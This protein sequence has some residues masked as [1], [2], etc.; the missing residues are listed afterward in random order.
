MRGAVCLALVL[1]M[2]L[3]NKD[4][5]QILL[6]TALFILLFTIVF[7][8]GSTLPLIKILS[9]LFPNERGNRPNKRKRSRKQRNQ[10]GKVRRSSPVLLSKTQ[11]MV[12]FDNSEHFTTTEYEDD[13]NNR[14]TMYQRK[15]VFTKINERIVRPLFVRKFT[16]QERQENKQRFKNLASEVLKSTDNLDETSSDEYFNSSTTGAGTPLIPR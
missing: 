15:N 11:E 16:Q 10:K 12:N 9:N 8:G 3:E 4:T 6:T 1:H 7:M 2:E 13:G 14:H 5:K